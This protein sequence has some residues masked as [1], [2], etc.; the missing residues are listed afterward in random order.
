LKLLG[1]V[2][3][4]FLL[5]LWVGVLY[6]RVIFL[7]GT[8][9]SSGEI[10]PFASRIA[11]IFIWANLIFFFSKDLSLLLF[12]FV[13][14]ILLF[15][16]SDLINFFRPFAPAELLR[17]DVWSDNS[18]YCWSDGC[19]WFMSYLCSEINYSLYLLCA[20]VDFGLLNE[21]RCSGD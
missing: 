17:E 12:L 14:K 3:W 15:I 13:L 10:A 21:L 6:F 16:D 8:S 1:Y 19:S 18:C 9:V 20:F 11:A 7:L 4:I 5:L 2:S